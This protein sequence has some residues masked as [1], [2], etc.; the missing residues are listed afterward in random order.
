MADRFIGL[1]EGKTRDF[2]NFSRI[3]N[4]AADLRCNLLKEEKE[5]KKNTYLYHFK[6]NRF[7]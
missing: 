1:D 5:E 2:F 6:K 4:G 3:K 7:T